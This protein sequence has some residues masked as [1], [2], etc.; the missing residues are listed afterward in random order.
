MH[1]VETALYNYMLKFDV[2][3]E[4]AAERGPKLRTKGNSEGRS[5]RS[6]RRFC[7]L[8]LKDIPGVLIGSVVGA[9]IPVLFSPSCH[10][11]RWAAPVWAGNQIKSLINS[12][13][14]GSDPE[15]K[16]ALHKGSGRRLDGKH[17]ER[18]N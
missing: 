3:E 14:E 18:K 6:R 7:C 1:P 11:V 13:F 8:A 15:P 2:K 10:E 17:R 5:R 4:T 12:A 9:G 16:R